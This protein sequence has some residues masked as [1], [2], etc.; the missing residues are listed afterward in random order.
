MSNIP[1][2]FLPSLLCDS[3]LWQAQIQG[4]SGQITPY[5]ADLTQRDTIP[6]MARDVLAKAPPRCRGRAGRESG[7]E[8]PRCRPP[9]TS[10]AVPPGS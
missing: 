7:G 6:D 1:V 5:V 8:A 4:F 9:A 3:A 10:G 2:V